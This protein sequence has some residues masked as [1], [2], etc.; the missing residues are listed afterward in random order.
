[1]AYDTVLRD[2]V[3][4]LDKETKEPL[5]VFKTT[6]ICS[7]YLGTNTYFI[8]QIMRK[9]KPNKYPFDFMLALDWEEEH[10]EVLPGGAVKRIALPL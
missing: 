8:R 2:R 1:M 5:C 4:I 10:D 7:L 3:V 9:E 6:Y